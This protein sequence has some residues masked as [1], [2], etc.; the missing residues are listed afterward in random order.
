M[1][2][3][4]VMARITTILLLLLLPQ[5]ALCGGGERLGIALYIAPGKDG[6][7]VTPEWMEEQVA[8]ANSLFAEMDL[9]FEVAETHNLEPDEAR[10]EGK[11]ARDLLGRTRYKKGLI[12]VFVVGYLG[13]VDEKGEIYGVHWRD[14][15]KTSRRWIILSAIAWDFTLVHELGHFFGL[16]HCDLPASIMNKTGKDPTPMAERGFTPS[17][18]KTMKRRLKRKLKSGAVENRA[19]SPE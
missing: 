10:I 5:T 15:K 17:E 6:P 4:N 3:M 18:L 9:V 11:E 1:G 7:V 12:H 13:N 8:K 14:R 19:N 2:S 16:S